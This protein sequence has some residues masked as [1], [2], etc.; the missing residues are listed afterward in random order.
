METIFYVFAT[1]LAL[2]VLIA[3]IKKVAKYIVVVG[4][5]ATLSL[6][7][8]GVGLQSRP[9]KD[10]TLSDWTDI[11]AEQ[12]QKYSDKI[13]NNEQAQAIYSEMVELLNNKAEEV[14]EDSMR[15]LIKKLE[16]I[17]EDNYK[18][19]TDSASVSTD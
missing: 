10:L 14:R 7:L 2:G 6:A 4:I 16:E 8:I 12:Y 15:V 17:P 19:T 1:I 9:V 3:I 13:E 18:M 5:F 11:T